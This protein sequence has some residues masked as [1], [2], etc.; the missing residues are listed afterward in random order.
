MNFSK[1]SRISTEAKD[2]REEAEGE[3]KWELRL[4]DH[5]QRFGASLD[6][7]HLFG[8]LVSPARSLAQVPKAQP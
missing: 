3:G 7:T 4:E 1:H 5:T 8:G 6:F 2:A